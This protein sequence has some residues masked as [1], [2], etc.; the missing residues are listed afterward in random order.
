MASATQQQ[1]G[2]IPAFEEYMPQ[3]F[4]EALRLS[5][6]NKVV[7]GVPGLQLVSEPLHEEADL[8]EAHAQLL[9]PSALLFAVELYRRS[10]SFK[11]SL[12]SVLAHRKMKR[13]YLNLA[14]ANGSQRV[15]AAT[16]SPSSP[17][18][19]VVL[20]DG[21]VALGF[22]TDTKAIREDPSW[23]VAPIPAS[24]ARFHDTITAPP[25]A[26]PIAKALTCGVHFLMVDFE[27]S[28]TV[29]LKSLLAGLHACTLANRRQL[30]LGRLILFLCVFF[31]FSLHFD[32][33]DCCMA[34]IRT[35]ICGGQRDCAA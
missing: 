21:T 19:D 32:W 22:R 4:L 26:L 23:R 3:A 5:A 12:Q 2:P 10:L 7:V 11:H 25:A 9:S 18:R 30:R 28:S 13:R 16:S 17:L 29:A 20:H 35:A 33:L 8:E 15:G 1:Q 34:N 24:F 14:A 27:D 6:S 31:D